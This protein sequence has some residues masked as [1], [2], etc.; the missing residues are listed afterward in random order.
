MVDPAVSRA[1]FAREVADYR[2]MEAEYLKRGWMLLRAEYPVVVIAF[3]AAHL[4]PPAVL[5]AVRVDFLNYDVWAPSVSFV[6]PFTLE[7]LLIDRLP[8]RL[9]KRVRAESAMPPEVL[10]GLLAQLGAGP[11]PQ[12]DDGAVGGVP[13]VWAT[14][15]LVQAHADGVPFL[16]IAGV[17]EYHDHPVHS[18]DP[19]LS[20]RATGV[21]RLYHILDIIWRH[22][23]LPLGGWGVDFAGVRLSLQLHPERVPE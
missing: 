4:Q 11:L 20:H 9:P 17:R 12:S 21:G 18:N 19:W 5:Y 3:A 8:N 1:K 6:D 14:Q 10:A 16:C 23:V 22:G 2:A 15:E 7:P 13:P